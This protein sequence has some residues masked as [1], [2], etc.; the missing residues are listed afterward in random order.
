MKSYWIR[1]A[2][3]RTEL[4]CRESP[5]PQPGPNEIVLAVHAAG[6]NRGEL[7]V[8]GVMHGGAE[9]PGGT[10]AAGIVHAVGSGANAFYPGQRVMGR[11]KPPGGGFGDYV[12]MR[13]DLAI[14]F[15]RRLTW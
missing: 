4:E 14:E 11:V 3:A 8:G 5:V 12:A 15:P 10:E 9:K 2:G 13:A 6:L 7:F 1:T